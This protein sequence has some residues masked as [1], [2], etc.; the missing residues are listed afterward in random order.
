ME[1][2]PVVGEGGGEGL[3]DE[4]DEDE[5]AWREKGNAKEMTRQWLQG[6]TA[7][8]ILR[9]KTLLRQQL[10]ASRLLMVFVVVAAFCCRVCCSESAMFFFFSWFCLFV[11]CWFTFF[12]F[13][14]MVVALAL[15]LCCLCSV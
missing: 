10:E 2:V 9:D 12:F 7:E 4:E 5:V 15:F 14:A 8:D 1:G 13:R 6:F 11:V 3:I